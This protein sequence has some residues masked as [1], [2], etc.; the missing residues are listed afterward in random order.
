MTLWGVRCVTVW[1]V[2]CVTVWGVR[3]VAVCE[4]C[5]CGS[6]MCDEYCSKGVP[7]VHH[8]FVIIVYALGILFSGSWSE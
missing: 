4:M 3:C 2:R 8:V 1:G 7:N 5:G 6:E